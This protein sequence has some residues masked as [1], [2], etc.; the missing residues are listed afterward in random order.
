MIFF[1]FFHF[2]FHFIISIY[3][4][5][6]FFDIEENMIKFDRQTTGFYVLR[7]IPLQNFSSAGISQ[8]RNSKVMLFVKCTETHLFAAKYDKWALKTSVH[9]YFYLV[10]KGCY[11]NSYSKNIFLF[12]L[13]FDN[14]I[15]PEFE[16]YSA[17][18]KSRGYS[19]VYNTISE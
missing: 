3:L 19:N 14:F 9:I 2:F 1:P 8:M 7:Q 17:S 12:R 15:F 6:L 4:L 13:S 11:I 18:H 16:Y 10:K 5:F